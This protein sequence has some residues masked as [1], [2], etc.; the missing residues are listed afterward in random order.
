MPTHSPGNEAGSA[1]GAAGGAPLGAGGGAPLGAGGPPPDEVMGPVRESVVVLADAMPG[2]TAA[3]Y[4]Q[5]VSLVPTILQTSSDHGHAL[6]EEL[7]QH[8]VRA[9][10]G[11]DPPDSVT[12][13]LG[14][15]GAQLYRQGLPIDGYQGAAHA[16]LRAARDSYPHDWE[17]TLS[18]AWVAFLGWAVEHMAQGAQAARLGGA[19]LPAVQVPA[20][21]PAPGSL[22]QILPFLRAGP[23]EGNPKALDSVVTRVA[24]RTGV[25]LRFPRMDQQGDP[26]LVATVLSILTR[27]G[28]VVAEL[29]V[30]T[31]AREG[32][33]PAPMSA[34]MSAPGPA[35]PTVQADPPRRARW[36]KRRSPAATAGPAGLPPTA[37]PVG[38]EPV[39]AP[40]A[41][42]VGAAPGT[43]GTPAGGLRGRFDA[44]SGLGLAV[45][46]AG[47]PPP[48]PP[49][50]L[51]ELLGTLRTGVFAD[52]EWALEGVA[53][54]VALRTGADIRAPRPDQVAD[55]AV[56]RDVLAVLGRMGYAE[57]DSAAVR[58][59]WWARQRRRDRIA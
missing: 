18:S 4:D 36:W 20:A 1:S 45:P 41:S 12:E 13:H 48:Q 5:L 31:P 24:L 35:R 54:R 6:A 7:T 16:V 30:P 39:A 14:R 43:P 27:M 17:S 11:A 53:T 9:A 23:F 26:D 29:P 50:T 28:Y 33:R 37:L 49:R 8:L 38:S 25:D 56:V 58:P 47:G 3:C 40:V 34:P 46:A 19:R 57:T 52:N 59:R 32:W 44:F 55:P 15:A 10:S 2:F 21:A 51:T 42:L 22:G